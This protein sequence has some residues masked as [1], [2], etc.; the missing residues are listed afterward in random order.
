MGANMKVKNI[1]CIGAG[2]VGGPSMAVIAD[3]CHDIKVTV[4]DL[5]EERIRLWNTDNLPVFEPGLDEVVFRR[6]DKNLFFK[7]V[8]PEI[9]NEADMIFVS[10][11]TPTKEYGKGAGMAADLKYWEKSARDIL[12]HAKSGAIVVEKSTVP[13]KTAEAI[14]RILHSGDEGK[15]FQVLSNPEFL[16]EGTAVQDLMEP[17]RVLIGG[18]NTSEGR[19]AAESLAEVYRQWIPTDQVLITNVWSSELA[20][21]VANAFLAQRVS[22]INAVSAI[23]EKSGADIHEISKAIGMDSRIGSK[24]LQAGVG[25]GGSCFRKD[26]LNMA[27]VCETLGLPEVSAYWKSVVDMNDY[28]MNRFVRTIV[29]NQFNTVAGKKIAIFG[30]AFKP[31][32]NDTR[33]TPA[34]PVCE[35]LLEEKAKLII[36]DPK[37]LDNAKLDMSKYDDIIYEADPY[38]AAEGAHALV[39]IT[40]WNEF[41]DL[42][43]KKI[44]DSMEKPAFLFDGRSFLDHGKLFDIGFNVFPIGKAS[45]THF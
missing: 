8:S 1:V 42:D 24:F 12:A 30:F 23:C 2:Y 20:K 10:V 25:F 26:I 35:G 38:K 27:Y 18:E 21:L 15:K 39:F 31:D 41:K 13:V 22:S 32:T 40:H 11:N 34:V 36:H 6:R 7:V 37:A 17:D 44:F 45:R 28:Q 5:N 33:D 4:V 29:D 9:L 19:E 3:K 16:A 43:Y 14:S